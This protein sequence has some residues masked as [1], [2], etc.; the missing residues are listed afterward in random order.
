MSADNAGDELWVAA[1]GEVAATGSA[2][3]AEALL[4]QAETA[5]KIS[6]PPTITRCLMALSPMITVFLAAVSC[7]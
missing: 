6:A 2:G 7:S 3:L 5:A 1:T 4:L